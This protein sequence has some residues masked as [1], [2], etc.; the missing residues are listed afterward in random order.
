MVIEVSEIH[1]PKPGGKVSRIVAADG[2]RYEIWPDK[3]AGVAPGRRYDVE[4]AERQYN[5]R[6]IKSIRK[7][8][9]LA[10]KPKSQ[11]STGEIPQLN[12]ENHPGEAE[13]VG[14]VLAALI[15]KGEVTVNQVPAYTMRLR[16]VWRQQ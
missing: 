16:E 4:I 13:Y 11:P 2:E 7:I 3:L 1:P 5:E 10:E 9:P 6:T 14:R 15:A 8:T 12:R